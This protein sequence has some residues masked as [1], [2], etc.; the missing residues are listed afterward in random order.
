[1][2]TRLL[3]KPKEAPKRGALS[4]AGWEALM[5]R[6][7]SR[8]ER[9]QDRRLDGLKRAMQEG[10][11]ETFLRKLGIICETDLLREFPDPST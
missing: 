7:I 11:S 4:P 3:N 6:A 8:A 10:K 2:R 5:Q 1:M 9:L